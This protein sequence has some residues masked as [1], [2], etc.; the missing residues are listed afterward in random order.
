MFLKRNIGL[1]QYRKEGRLEIM[2]D[3]ELK[4][5]DKKRKIIESFQDII[6]NN[7]QNNENTGDYSIHDLAV[8]NLQRENFILSK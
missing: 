4:I 7:Y 6:E 8:L 2:L 1:G 5:E 3:V